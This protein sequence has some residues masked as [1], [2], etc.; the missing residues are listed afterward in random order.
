MGGGGAI[1]ELFVSYSRTF[2][3]H[4]R[5]DTVTLCIK[6]LMASLPNKAKSS[7]TYRFKRQQL[8]NSVLLALELVSAE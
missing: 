6:L 2:T 8:R 4:Y 5:N 7:G 3:F 1:T